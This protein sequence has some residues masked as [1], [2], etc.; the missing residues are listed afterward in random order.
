MTTKEE[1][2]KINQYCSDINVIGKS[3]IVLSN[4]DWNEVYKDLDRLEKLE[5]AFEV[6][7]KSL[8]LSVVEIHEHYYVCAHDNNYFIKKEEADLIKEALEDE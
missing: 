3:D 8:L 2:K 5:K 4:E 1:I 6:L 7:K